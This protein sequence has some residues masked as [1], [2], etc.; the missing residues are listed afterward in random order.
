LKRTFAAAVILIVPCPAF[1]QTPLE[2]TPRE[3][4]VAPG[5]KIIYYIMQMPSTDAAGNPKL[6]IEETRNLNR[7]FRTLL[8]SRSAADPKQNLTGFS[9]LNLSP[10]GKILYF[11]TDA[12][13][14][15]NAIH[16]I[17]L[18]TGEVSYVTSGEIACVVLSGEYQ[19]DLVV[20]QHRYFVQGG[21]HDDLWLY[22]STAK[23]LKAQT[24]RRCAQPWPIE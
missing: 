19:G 6:Q 11:Q 22:N 16:T 3:H 15:A 1:A 9:N 12:W 2:Q 21:S 23:W 20:E 8:T 24:Q 14:T 5:G 4:V 10:D 18:A 13:A 7:S 17:N